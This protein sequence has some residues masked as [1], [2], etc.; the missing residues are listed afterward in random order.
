MKKIMVIAM[1][2]IHDPASME[3]FLDLYYCD[4][5]EIDNREALITFIEQIAKKAGTTVLKT[6]IYSYKPQGYTAIGILSDSSVVIHTWPEYR[7]VNI[8]IFTCGFHRGIDPRKAVGY[9]YQTLR[10]GVMC[11][12]T[13]KRNRRFWGKCGKIMKK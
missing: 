13:V 6:Y 11:T 12:R 3:V 8:N 9:I 4:V 7:L 1:S 10:P 5:K 2:E